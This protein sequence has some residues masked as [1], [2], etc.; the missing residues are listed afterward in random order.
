MPILNT[1]VLSLDARAKTVGELTSKIEPKTEGDEEKVSVAVACKWAHPLNVSY[2]IQYLR[3]RS[4]VFSE[5]LL[6]PLP[7]HKF[8]SINLW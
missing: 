8:G 3:A 7:E 4:R 6:G 5:D 1:N 2:S